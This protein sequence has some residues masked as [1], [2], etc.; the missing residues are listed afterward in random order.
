[1]IRFVGEKMYYSQVDVAYELALYLQQ[2][3]EGT[4]KKPCIF[5][6]CAERLKMKLPDLK[7]IVQAEE[8]EKVS[9]EK[10]RVICEKTD[11]CDSQSGYIPAG[12]DDMYKALVSIVYSRIMDDMMGGASVQACQTYLRQMEEGYRDKAAEP[13]IVKNEV[14]YDDETRAA[15]LASTDPD[16]I[17]RLAKGYGR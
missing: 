1:M 7:L 8:S 16:T 6:F 12:I 5:K 15:I 13:I 3:E 14:S 4:V 9:K 2:I 10:D 11:G 17:T